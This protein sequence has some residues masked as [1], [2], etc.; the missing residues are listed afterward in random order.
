MKIKQFKSRSS[1]FG[2]MPDYK[3]GGGLRL[4]ESCLEQTLR[5]SM[6]RPCDRFLN[7]LDD[8]WLNSSF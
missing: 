2:L 5:T 1:V 6:L 3:G 7:G 8:I 4:D